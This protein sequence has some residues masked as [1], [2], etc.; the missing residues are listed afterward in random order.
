[1]IEHCIF[2]LKSLR[3][4]KLYRVYVT[5][6]LMAIADNTTHLVG[7]QGVVDYGKTIK[8]RWIDILNPP[9]EIPEDNRPSEEIASDIWKRIRGH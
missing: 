1:V 3:E 5:D 8:E 6:A 2:T 7:T 9:P 4:E